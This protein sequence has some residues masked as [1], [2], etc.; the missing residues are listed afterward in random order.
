MCDGPPKTEEEE[1]LEKKDPAAA[2]REIKLLSLQ[3][4][5]NDFNGILHISYNILILL[6]HFNRL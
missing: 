5:L 4:V 3:K 6:E 2:V 1:I